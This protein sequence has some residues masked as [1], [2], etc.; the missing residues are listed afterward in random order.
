[1]KRELLDLL[2]SDRAG[3][4]AVALVTDL[5][6]G[7]QCLMYADGTVFHPGGQPVDIQDE[8]SDA[9]LRC[10]REHRSSAFEIDGSRFIAI[11]RTGL[12]EDL[13]GDA[14]DADIVQQGRD[15]H[16]IAFLVFQ[17]HH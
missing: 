5:D 15:F 12:Q 3:R 8:L 17:V 13:V 4:R 10:L 11:Q 14:D 7:L 16:R 1:M 6:T 9:A 2:L